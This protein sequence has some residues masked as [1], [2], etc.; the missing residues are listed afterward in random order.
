[1]EKELEKY[2]PEKLVAEAEKKMRERLRAL[3][4]EFLKGL[5]LSPGDG[6]KSKHFTIRRTDNDFV[7]MVNDDSGWFFTY[8]Y[9]KDR[10]EV[11]Y[12]K[13]RYDMTFAASNIKE[14]AKAEVFIRHLVNDEEM[15]LHRLNNLAQHHSS[16]SST[17]EEILNEL[18]YEACKKMENLSLK[19]DAI[20][21]TVAIYGAPREYMIENVIFDSRWHRRVY[22]IFGKDSEPK[23]AVR[24]DFRTKSADVFKAACFAIQDI[25]DSRHPAELVEKLRTDEKIPYGEKA[26]AIQEA[27]H[28]DIEDV[29]NE[30]MICECRLLAAMLKSHENQSR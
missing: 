19:A 29:V 6:M 9:E 24:L 21:D 26:M 14:L 16:L 15:H 1:M 17:Q 23:T 3:S 18:A 10:V 28:E 12:D 30:L 2:T 22:F 27:I 13:L 5:G 4:R 7:L 25:A 11:K 20:F 8:S